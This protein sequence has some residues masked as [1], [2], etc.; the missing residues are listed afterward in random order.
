MTWLPILEYSDFH[1]V[2]RLMLLLVDG[3]FLVLNCPFDSELDDYA[4]DHV[5]WEL[6]ADLVNLLT[7]TGTDRP[8]GADF[9]GRAG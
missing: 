9:S 8:S 3:R 4:A 2:P 7:P 6:P 1:D 5:V